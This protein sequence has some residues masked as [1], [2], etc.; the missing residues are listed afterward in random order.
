MRGRVV[1]RGDLG[2]EQQRPVEDLVEVHVLREALGEGVVH[3]GDRP[4]ATH[5]LR[6]RVAR[7]VGVGAARLDAQQRRDRLQVVLHAMVDL[8]DRRV[9]GDEL[10]L[11]VA[12]LGD[13]AAEHD[14]ADALAAMPDGDRP[15]R[16]GHAP[17][18]DVGAPRRPAGDHERQ[19][20]VDD[21]LA[22]RAGAS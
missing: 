16:H 18:L 22:A 8:A 9:L 21:E 19:R 10:L 2:D 12:Q 1:R 13:V 15:Q 17:R 20:L 7:L 3:D 4:D 14:R 11:L 5:R 6:Q